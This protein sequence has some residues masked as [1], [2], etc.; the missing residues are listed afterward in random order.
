MKLTFT[1]DGSF[2]LPPD[3]LCTFERN[4]KTMHCNVD[5]LI[6]D[7][8]EQQAELIDIGKILKQTNTVNEE[9]AMKT[10]VNIPIII[11]CFD[12]GTYEILDG[13]HRLFRAAHEGKTQILA[14]ILNE[15]ELN[16]YLLW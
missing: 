6:D 2:M 7:Y 16:K 4:G 15:L 13:N 3:Q 12:D 8:K 14:H 9:Y 11:V 1:G 10:D 5:L